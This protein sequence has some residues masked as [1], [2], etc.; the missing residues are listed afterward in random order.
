MKLLEVR[1]LTFSYGEVL[2]LHAFNMEL[3]PHE[4]VLIDG[5]EGA[6]KTTLLKCVAHGLSEGDD[7]FI[8][9]RSVK[10]DKTLKQQISFVQSEDALYDYLTLDE[11]IRFFQSLL[12]ED[13]AF[14]TKARNMCE[15]FGIEK[16]ENY[17]VQSMPQATR[18]KLYLAIMFSKR[19]NILI[20]DEPFTALDK[21]TQRRVITKVKRFAKQANHALLIVTKVETLRAIATRTIEVQKIAI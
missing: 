13:D 11:N 14:V 15:E 21:R 2:V 19:H 16:Y 3:L 18:Q 1:D 6:G 8:N 17:L 5:E 9:G 10:T 20:L 4:I 7:I 12:D